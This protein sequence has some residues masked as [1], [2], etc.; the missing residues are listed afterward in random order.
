MNIYPYRVIPVVIRLGHSLIR[1]TYIA[2]LVFCLAADST[3]VLAPLFENPLPPAF[4]RLVSLLASILAV[5]ITHTR[6]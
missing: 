6:A 4:S 3:P 5:P 2:R 1:C